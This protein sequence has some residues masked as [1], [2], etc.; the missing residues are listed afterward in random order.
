MIEAEFKQFLK[1][2]PDEV[3]KALFIWATACMEVRG[4]IDIAG[5]VPARKRRS[6]AGG[7]RNG[8]TPETAFAR[9]NATVEAVRERLQ[10]SLSSPSH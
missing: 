8:T 6:D 9:G 7:K 4:L 10:P 5:S 3:A 2:A 1:D